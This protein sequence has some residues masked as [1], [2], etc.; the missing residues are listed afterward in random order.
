MLKSLL[1]H[2][3]RL[4]PSQE[5]DPNLLNPKCRLAM[6]FDRGYDVDGHLQ[7][8]LGDLCEHLQSAAIL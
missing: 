5:I 6:Q 7:R 3:K 4:R 1:G 2:R 8:W